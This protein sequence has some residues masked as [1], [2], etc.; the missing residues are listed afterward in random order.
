MISVSA[1]HQFAVNRWNPGYTGG[2][3]SGQGGQG[4]KLMSAQEGSEQATGQ[5]GPAASSGGSFILFV[6]SFIQSPPP[7]SCTSNTPCP[8]KS[9]QFAFW[10]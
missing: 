2:S 1:G 4:A 7:L 9:S 3:K 10:Q 5:G 6:F 8:K